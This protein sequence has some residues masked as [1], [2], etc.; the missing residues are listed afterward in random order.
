MQGKYAADASRQTHVAL[1]GLK[2][3][4]NG[5]GEAVQLFILSPKSHHLLL[6]SE[7]IFATSGQ[8]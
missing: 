8:Y 7:L 2:N 5:E 4:Y 3:W 6:F 1:S